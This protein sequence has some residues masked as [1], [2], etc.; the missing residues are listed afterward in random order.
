MD[1]ANG[2]K[3]FNVEC[4]LKGVDGSEGLTALPDSY[5][6]LVVTDEMDTQWIDMVKDL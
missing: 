2:K 6:P 5:K 1:R 3:K 4:G